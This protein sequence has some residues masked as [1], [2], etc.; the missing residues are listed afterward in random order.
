[1]AA[2]GV[3]VSHE[4]VPEWCDKF[5]AAYAKENREGVPGRVTSGLST[6]SS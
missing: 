4:T 3:E 1:M 5:G 6:R 2:R